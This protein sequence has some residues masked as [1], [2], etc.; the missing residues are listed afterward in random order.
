MRK[1]SVYLSDETKEALRQVSR[2]WN[3]SEAQ[4]IREAIDRLVRSA[5]AESAPAPAPSPASPTS[6]GPRL[7][8]VGVGPSA[9]DLITRRAVDV[10]EHADRVFAAST[11]PDA[12]SR[13]ETI[14]RSAAP[15]VAVDRLPFVATE[16]PEGLEG[17]FERAVDTI[18]A[19]L[20]RGE[21]AAFITLGDPNVY[22]VFSE[23]ARRVDAARPGI[24][25]SVV[26]GIMAFQE[27]AA[28]TGTVLAEGEERI[29]V[30]TMGDDRAS[31]A[32]ALGDARSTVV[33]YKGGRLLPELAVQ[34]RD[35]ERLE[36]AVVGELMGLPGGRNGPVADVADRPASY[37]ATVIVPARRDDRP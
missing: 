23:L 16:R 28:S 20:D 34:L 9:P 12:I 14:V 36:G 30:G 3:R 18:V 13:A 17:S 2:R 33:L 5:A 1:T 27:L 35:C 19:V 11:A 26:P 31:F 10:L 7:I 24:P 4:L 8:G 37:L 22:S 32:G 29:E 25:V 21:V 6:Q 15:H